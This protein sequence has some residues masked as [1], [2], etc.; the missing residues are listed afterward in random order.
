MFK[1]IVERPRVPAHGNRERR[2]PVDEN[3]RSRESLRR[4]HTDRK[5]LNENLAPLARFLCKQVG[6]PW[7]KVHAE[8]CKGIDRR[9]TVQQHIHQH[10]DDYVITE[11]IVI[12][13][14]LHFQHRWMG[15]RALDGDWVHQDLYVCPSTGLRRELEGMPTRM[16]NFTEAVYGP[17]ALD[18]AWHEFML[19]EDG[20]EEFDPDTPHM[21]VFMPWFFHHWTPSPDDTQFGD[22][23][24]I[25]VTPTQAYLQRKG[26][27]LDPAVREYLASCGEHMPSFFDVERSEPGHSLWLRDMLTGQTHHVLERNASRALR[28]GDLVYGQIAS[29]LGVTLLEATSPVVLPPQD[30]VAVIQQRKRMQSSEYHD[31]IRFEYDIEL[32]ELYLKLAGAILYPQPPMMRT[33][34]GEDLEYHTLV[35]A[36]DSPQFAFDA[37]KDLDIVNDESDLL[38]QASHDENG[39]LR[40]VE[41]AWSKLGNTLHPEWDNTILG[42]LFIDEGHLTAEVNSRERAEALR[43]IVAERLGGHAR[44]RHDETKSVEQLLAQESPSQRRPAMDADMQAMADQYLQQHCTAW[45]DEALPALGGLTPRQ[46]V[47]ES[48]GREQ[49]EALLCQL[50]R[51]AAG[52]PVYRAILPMLREQLGLGT[53]SG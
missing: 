7:D 26:P 43:A 29:A 44:F 27:R 18:E 39:N 8:I 24:L 19:W 10:L 37:L 1:L 23:A 5:T 20:E 52:Q 25:G 3:S 49:V 33:T 4:R 35:F 2:E 38:S 17:L 53:V 6:R 12:D 13:G 34:D 40:R 14:R 30:K 22:P 51:S 36:I 46:A 48:D 9:N 45:L 11:V 32:R 42:H 31:D 15:L 47:Q 16:L 28:A 21:P 41:I 50:E